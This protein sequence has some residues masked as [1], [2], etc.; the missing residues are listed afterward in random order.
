VPCYV[1]VMLVNEEF[2]SSIVLVVEEEGLSAQGEVG[3]LRTSND[4]SP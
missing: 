3:S 1:N 2:V 4:C